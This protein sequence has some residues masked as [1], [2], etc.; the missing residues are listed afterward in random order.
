MDLKSHG[1]FALAK[2]EKAR[3]EGQVE[4]VR[5]G[6]TGPAQHLRGT[7][8]EGWMGRTINY[9]PV[10]EPSGYA[11]GGGAHIAAEC[12]LI[13]ASGDAMFAISETTRGMSGSR[14]WAKI[15]TFMPSKVANEMLLT[16]RRPRQ[17]SCISLD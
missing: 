13:V 16:G 14:T 5:K 3:Q 17:P 8:G 9:K 10:I 15:R 7:G 11:L 2:D 6:A 4:T 1:S 12:D